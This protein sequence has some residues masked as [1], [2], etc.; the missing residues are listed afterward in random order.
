MFTQFSFGSL[1]QTVADLWQFIRRF[2][3]TWIQTKYACKTVLAFLYSSWNLS[4]G[5][6]AVSRVWII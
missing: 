5:G 1:K 2:V 6:S 4:Q 3:Y